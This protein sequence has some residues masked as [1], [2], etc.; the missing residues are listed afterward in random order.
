MAKR[1]LLVLVLLALPAAATI[2]KVQSAATWNTTSTT[3]CTVALTSTTDHN[4]LVVWGTWSP[5]TLSASVVDHAN[6]T[7]FPSAVGPTIQSASNTAAQ[8]VYQN[9]I[10]HTTGTDNVVVTFNGTATT[11]SC[12][13]VEYS[14]ADLNYPLDSVSAGYST[15]GNPTSLSDSGTVAPANANLL[16]F[17]GGIN[18]GGTVIAGSGFTGIQA[19]SVGS[20]GAITEQNTSAIS[21]NNV[22][23]RATACVGSGS[24]CSAGIGNWLMQ[25]AV[26]R[27]ASWTVAAGW[28]PARTGQIFDASLFPGGIPSA[29]ASAI[30]LNGGTILSPS[31]YNP[32]ITSGL[33]LGNTTVPVHLHF[34]SNSQLTCN[35]TGGS[36]TCL[37]EGYHSR[38]S[39][40]GVINSTIQGSGTQNADDMLANSTASEYFQFD[41]FLLTTGMGDTFTKAAV[42]IE[43]GFVPSYFDNVFISCE[44]GNGGS[45]RNSTIASYRYFALATWETTPG[46]GGRMFVNDRIYSK[47]PSP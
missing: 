9:N 38:I 28:S 30:T 39:G 22:L 2:S 20:G 3:T 19:H 26:F 13:A 4:L 5:S 17:G 36:G 35:L 24:L 10:N 34:G 40:D 43:G 21:G 7:A 11:A 15:S 31:G 16:V 14:G 6:T 25:M 1:L 45:L 37:T 47:I 27:D 12:V 41:H 44:H 29:N 8:I 33:T 23:Q 46:K 42:E 32:T 18:D